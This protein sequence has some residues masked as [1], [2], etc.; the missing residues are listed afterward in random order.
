VSWLTGHGALR[1]MYLE[2]TAIGGEDGVGQ[3][4]TRAY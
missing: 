3:V 4:V 1:R 2:V